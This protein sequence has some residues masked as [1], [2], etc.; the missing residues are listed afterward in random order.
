M[1]YFVS[2]T[3]ASINSL[4]NLYT[5]PVKSV[6]YKLKVAALALFLIVSSMNKEA[7]GAESHSRQEN[8]HT[9]EFVELWRDPFPAT[10]LSGVEVTLD[11]TIYKIYASHASKFWQRQESLDKL[12]E[13]FYANFNKGETDIDSF[14]PLFK[15]MANELSALKIDYSF[16]DVSRKK[17]MIDFNLNLEEG[18]FLSVAD[19]SVHFFFLPSAAF[20]A[21][22]SAGKRDAFPPPVPFS[23]FDCRQPKIAGNIH[24]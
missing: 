8:Q 6:G 16:V 21:V 2:T 15:T 7:Y 13:S 12:R 17:G 14:S 19:C 23:L 9:T 24:C 11:R 22:V 5:A 20:A 18:V 1:D 4:E 3:D 10:Q